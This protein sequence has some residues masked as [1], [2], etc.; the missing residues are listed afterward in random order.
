[1]ISLPLHNKACSL[2]SAAELG[3]RMWDLQVRVATTCLPSFFTYE[4]FLTPSHHF[5]YQHHSSQLQWVNALKRRCK[6]T[7]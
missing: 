7:V 2:M 6:H 5:Y 3:D 1:M 4:Q